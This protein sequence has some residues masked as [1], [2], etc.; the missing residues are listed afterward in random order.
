M[1]RSVNHTIAY[2]RYC[3]N[4][5]SLPLRIPQRLKVK[6]RDRRHLIESTELILDLFFAPCTQ[7]WSLSISRALI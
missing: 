1:F 4:L 2:V 6:F 5:L 3:A 7:K